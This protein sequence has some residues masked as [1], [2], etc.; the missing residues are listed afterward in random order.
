MKIIDPFATLE[1]HHDTAVA[2]ALQSNAAQYI[3]YRVVEHLVDTDESL[4]VYGDLVGDLQFA[5]GYRMGLRVAYIA[6]G[7]QVDGS[8][9]G[10]AQLV[11]DQRG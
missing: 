11:E 1:A 7:G 4:V 10:W 3:R 9:E 5:R 8:E 6:A 2:V